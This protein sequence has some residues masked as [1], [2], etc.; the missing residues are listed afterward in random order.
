MATP[1]CKAGAKAKARTL[2]QIS[3]CILHHHMYVCRIS[4]EFGIL[5]AFA[6]PPGGVS[7]PPNHYHIKFCVNRINDKNG[8][9]QCS[10][11]LCGFWKSKKNTPRRGQGREICPLE[12]RPSSGTQRYVRGL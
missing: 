8:N 2:F 9:S 11:M 4:I 6:R 5:V 7:E 1:C 3:R 12:V 10:K